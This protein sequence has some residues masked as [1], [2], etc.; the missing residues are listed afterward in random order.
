MQN[1]FDRETARNTMNWAHKWTREHRSNYHTYAD[2]FREGL[3]LAH[4]WAAGKLHLLFST[5]NFNWYLVQEFANQ[6][7]QFLQ[8]Q[9]VSWKAPEYRDEWCQSVKSLENGDFVAANE[10]ARNAI[11]NM[12]SIFC[13]E[14]LIH[15]TNQ[16]SKLACAQKHGS[17]QVI[18]E[19]IPA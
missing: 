16:L 2:A 3:R 5:N 14:T 11:P 7:G 18:W 19:R 15:V 6:V 4:A 17:L 13:S 1:V 12:R 10:H 9:N 8:P